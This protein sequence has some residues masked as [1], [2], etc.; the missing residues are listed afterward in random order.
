[1]RRRLLRDRHAPSAAAHYDRRGPLARLL[2]PM[3]LS[4]ITPQ[5]TRGCSVGGAAER[6]N[7]VYANTLGGA[8]ASL[9]LPNTTSASTS[10]TCSPAWHSSPFPREANAVPPKF[11]TSGGLASDNEM[12]WPDR[13]PRREPSQHKRSRVENTSAACNQ[14]SVARGSQRQ[15]PSIPTLWFVL[16]SIYAFSAQIRVD[17]TCVD[18]LM[19][20]NQVR[21][22]VERVVRRVFGSHYSVEFFGSTR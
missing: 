22:H 3:N 12:S 17:A 16:P 2:L 21:A 15:L 1:M 13:V 18:V 10:R 4:R 6:D 20:R 11:N 7:R 8:G 9:L 19:A 5:S 14:W